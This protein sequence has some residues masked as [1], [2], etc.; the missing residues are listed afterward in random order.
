MCL[1]SKVE[2]QQKILSCVFSVSLEMGKSL[3]TW[4]WLLQLKAILLVLKT[5]LSKDV[6][7]TPAGD[8]A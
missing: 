1:C 8:V 5:V 6:S 2:L 3:E 4:E 7:Q